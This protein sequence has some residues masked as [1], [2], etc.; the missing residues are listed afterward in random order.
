MTMRSFS[1]KLALFFAYFMS[2]IFFVFPPFL[3]ATII[4][5]VS[6]RE[7]KKKFREELERIG[8]RNYREIETGK[9]KYLIFN[10][11]GRFMETIS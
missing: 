7:K 2:I 3:I 10:D 1:V 11:D 5:H 4:F 8:F 6:L 9:Y